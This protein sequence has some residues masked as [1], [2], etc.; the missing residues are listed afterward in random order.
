MSL[1]M[2]NTFNWPN[3][4]AQA[5]ESYGL[6]SREWFANWQLPYPVGVQY[7]H[8]VELAYL[9]DFL[10]QLTVATG[11]LLFIFRVH[12]FFSPTMLDSF[13]VSLMSSQ[14][15]ADVYRRAMNILDY[16]TD[17][18]AFSLVEHAG[19]RCIEV[20]M[21]EPEDYALCK[22]MMLTTTQKLMQILV[23]PDFSFKQ[24]QLD[25]AV[26]GAQEKALSLI[27]QCPIVWQT[28]KTALH[29][30][31][32]DL[33]K[34]LPGA[35]NDM[36]EVHEKMFYHRL[37]QTFDSKISLKVKNILI[38]HLSRGECTKDFV[39]EKLSI[40]GRTLQY[41]LEKEG[42]NFKQLLS[43]TRYEL[44]QSYLQQNRSLTEIA[45][46]LGYTDTSNFHRAL[47]AWKNT[48]S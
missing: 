24:L 47:K 1:L 34:L 16:V 11:D 14:N 28:E 44:A 23:A 21:H 9:E 25:F 12:Q 40:K 18:I 42:T 37:N 36:A 33:I 6:S 46:L 13:G 15:I 26:D 8:Q 43:D 41:Q 4:I 19:G 31:A 5:I 3:A 48:K 22:I 10:A 29:F 39:A 27:F 30:D 20:D 7:C 35:N 17:S 2:A 32:N 45:H 38:Q